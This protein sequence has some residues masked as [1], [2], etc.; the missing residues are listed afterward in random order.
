MLPDVVRGVGHDED[1]P[2]GC[3]EVAT[4]L[5]LRLGQPEDPRLLFR[6]IIRDNDGVPVGRLL[7]NALPARRLDGASIVQFTLIARGKPATPDLVGVSDF[8]TKGR[9]YIVRAF[10][11]LTSDEMHK[12]W[13][14]RQ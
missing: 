9:R 2:V 6:Y 11:Q 10:T 14:R 8:L 1:G 12:A 5:G 13:E 3:R 7:V 4:F